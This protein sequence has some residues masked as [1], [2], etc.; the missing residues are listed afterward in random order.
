M[1]PEMTV[2]AL[3]AIWQMG[4]IAIAGGV[5]NRDVG[6][7]YNTGPRDKDVNFSP[8]TGRLRRAVNNGFEALALFTIAVVVLTQSGNASGVTAAA[9]WVWLA[10]RL[11]Y[12]PAY[13]LGLSPWRSLIWA[14]GTLS[15]LILLGASLF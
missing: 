1:S 8:L 13:G 3:G 11:L 10:A 7:D 6:R 14:V 5:M 15:T 9:A 12:F 2:L 4:Q